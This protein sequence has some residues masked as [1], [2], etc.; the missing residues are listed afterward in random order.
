VEVFDKETTAQERL[1]ELI[2]RLEQ[3]YS[4]VEGRKEYDAEH[5]LAGWYKCQRDGCET[6]IRFNPNV[7]RLME[8][9]IAHEEE[10][11]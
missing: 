9:L 1:N 5:Q 6:E 8:E 11:E 3:H 10:H 7:P 2:R 4:Q